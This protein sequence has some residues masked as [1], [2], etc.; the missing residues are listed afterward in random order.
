MAMVQTNEKAIER[1]S[2]ML[3]RPSGNPS[4][5]QQFKPLPQSKSPLAYD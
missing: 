1:I 3:N 5:R 4:V 2:L